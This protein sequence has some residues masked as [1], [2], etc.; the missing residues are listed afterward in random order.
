MAFERDHTV[1]FGVTLRLE[2]N[3]HANVNMKH[4][5]Y[6]VL[7]ILVVYGTL[8]FLGGSIG[9][10]FPYQIWM[11]LWLGL[12]GLLFLWNLNDIFRR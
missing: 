5:H 1:W 4:I 10:I 12:V 7:V 8:R 6:R 9:G 3:G 2:A 11:Y